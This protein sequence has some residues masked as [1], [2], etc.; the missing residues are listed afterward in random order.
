MANRFGMPR[1]EIIGSLILATIVKISSQDSETAQNQPRQQL[2]V[3]PALRPNGS[4]G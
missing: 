1:Y 4:R 2:E 3:S